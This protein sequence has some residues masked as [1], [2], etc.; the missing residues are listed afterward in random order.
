M[1]QEKALFAP[2]KNQ[3]IFEKVSG[4]IKGLIFDGVLK[5][6]DRLPSETEL[7]QQFNVS[8]QTVRE[9]L[10]VLELSGFITTQKGGPKGPLIKDTIV[11]TISDLYLD[12]FRMEKISLGELTTARCEIERLVLNHVIEKA[13][14]SDLEA[15]RRNIMESKK[16]VAGNV[17]ALDENIEFHNLLA[18]ASKNHVFVIVVGSLTAAVRDFLTR[19]APLPDPSGETAVYEESVM[20]SKNTILYHEKILQAIE[21]RKKDAAGEILEEHLREVGARLQSLKGGSNE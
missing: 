10:R 18:T 13:D 12:A 6:G 15:L 21:E 16:R 20:K 19:I 1:R 11:N 7:A 17:V 9:A 4:S 14:V 8:R 5:T 3:R 2:L